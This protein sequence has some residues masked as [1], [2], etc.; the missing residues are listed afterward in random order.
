LPAGAVWSRA[1]WFGAV[2]SATAIFRD[3]EGSPP[4]RGQMVRDFLDVASRASAALLGV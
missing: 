2:L 3:V 1:R 4:A